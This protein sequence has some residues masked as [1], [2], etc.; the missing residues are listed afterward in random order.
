ML[1]ALTPN[2]AIDRLL[3]VPGFRQAEVV[4]VLERRDS[5]GGKGINVARVAR[6]LGQA[7]R[8]LA[9]LGGESGHTVALLAEQEGFDTRWAWMQQGETRICTLI[10]DPENY[11]TLTVNEPGPTLS[12]TDWAAL[13]ALVQTE[14]RQAQA[15][16]I[17]GSLMPGSELESFRALLSSVSSSCP[18]FLDTSG[19]ALRAALGL[20]LALI[21]VNAHEIAEVLGDPV[22][23]RDQAARAARTVCAM[24]AHM[25]V[26][27]LG[28][29]G[30]VAVSSSSAWAA[31]TA[32]VQSIS[33]V[34][35]GDATLAGIASGLLQGRSLE[36]ALA[37]GV[38]CGAANTLTI[39]PGRL[40]ADDLSRL[41]RSVEL[42]QL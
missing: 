21:K 12:A 31:S 22:E 27:T 11:D 9:L 39:G 40:K 25:V 42:E 4:R 23:S 6:I 19:S 34:G 32:P 30:A 26:I 17:S 3:I 36:K 8:V 41:L 18:V 7:V 24:G 10:T 16:A 37:L 1:L 15:L 28:E 35:S 38:A 29:Q 33:P 5:A 2:P 20:P 14:S 13:E